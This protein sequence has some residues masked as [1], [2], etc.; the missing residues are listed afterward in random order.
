[1]PWFFPRLLVLSV[2]SKFSWSSSLDS[3]EN[4]VRLSFV[5]T[6]FGFSLCAAQAAIIFGVIK[7][8]PLKVYLEDGYGIWI[9]NYLYYN[10]QPI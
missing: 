8:N 5:Y 10:V 3:I 6:L 9:E 7:L 4:S 1:M 2:F